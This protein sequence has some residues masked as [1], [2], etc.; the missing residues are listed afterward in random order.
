MTAP[1]GFRAA[2]AATRNSQKSMVG[3]PGW[4]RWVNRPLGRVFAAAAHTVGATPNQVTVLSTVVTLSAVAAVGLVRP[5][6]WSS[7]A[8][9]VAL[10]LGYALDSADGQLA[11]LRG[12]GS[13]AGEWLDHVTDAVKTSAIHLAVLV[14]WYRF[15]DQP[16][17]WLL[18]PIAFT[19]VASCFFF[20]VI[21][22]EMLRRAQGRGSSRRGPAPVG[23]AP[24]L[25]SLLVLPADY[26]LL[27]AS[28]ALLAAPAVFRVVYTAL[29]ACAVVFLLGG[30]R[31][32]FR[33]MSGFTR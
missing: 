1:G 2:F 4:S 6:W 31:N 5:S 28:V 26:G 30:W 3:A 15:Y 20:S 10:V 27:C 7:L 24:V 17:G 23:R 9:A 33:E 21:L 12:G 25:R 32:W 8:I 14:C 29:L 16:R 22:S 13:I 11:R 19:L 18:V